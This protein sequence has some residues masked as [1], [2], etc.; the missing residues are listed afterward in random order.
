[1]TEDAEVHRAV[2]GRGVL[3]TG[4]REAA[5]V[6]CT[7][8][9]SM[10]ANAFTVPFRNVSSAMHCPYLSETIQGGGLRLCEIRCS[11]PRLGVLIS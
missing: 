2:S 11:S 6:S 5:R 10:R 9:K 8:F 1:M 3:D 7:E 4:N